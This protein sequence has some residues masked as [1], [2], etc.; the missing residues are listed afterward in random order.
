MKISVYKCVN[1]LYNVKHLNDFSINNKQK[2]EKLFYQR[3]K[4]TI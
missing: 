2:I 3:K 1:K 4:D